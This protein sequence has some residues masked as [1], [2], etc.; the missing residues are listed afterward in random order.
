VTKTAGGVAAWRR[1]LAAGGGERRGGTQKQRIA[2]RNE[3]I[4]V[5]KAESVMAAKAAK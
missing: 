4:S 3:N 5:A 2:G 1:R